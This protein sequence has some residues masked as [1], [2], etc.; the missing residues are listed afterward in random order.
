[1]KKQILIAFGIFIL[2]LLPRNAFPQDYSKIRICDPSRPGPN[3]LPSLVIVDGLPSASN[4]LLNKLNP[5]II[6]S[7]NIKKDTLYDYCSK[8]V[9]CGLVI[10]TSKDSCN[11]GLKHILKQTDN[12]IFSHPLAE[13]ICNGKTLDKDANT[14]SELFQIKPSQVIKIKII[15][16]EKKKTKYKNGALLIKTK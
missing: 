16:P 7:I 9:Y 15:E 6:L 8:S 1:M 12:W 3:N 13:F 11:N 2:I 14:I 10:V 5:Q 4:A